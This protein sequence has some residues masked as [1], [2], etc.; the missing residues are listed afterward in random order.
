MKQCGKCGEWNGVNQES[1]YKCGHPLPMGEGY[2]KV[3]PR[4]N[5]TYSPRAEACE[6]CGGRL[7]VHYKPSQ[8]GGGSSG[9]EDGLRWW[10]IA[11]AIIW[12]IVGIIG[13]LIMKARG[14]GAGGRLIAISLTAIAVRFVLGVVLGGCAAIL[15]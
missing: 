14:D 9:G 12:P 8:G 3:C 6:Q 15:G 13:G 4:C 2:Q 5:L 1:C 7:S 10:M 11:A